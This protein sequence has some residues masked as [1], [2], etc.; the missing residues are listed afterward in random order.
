M[1]YIQLKSQIIKLETR[2]VKL[3]D[4]CTI[5]SAMEIPN[6]NIGKVQKGNSFF[7][8]SAIELIKILQD[9]YP[10]EQFNFI[11]SSD[12]CVEYINTKKQNRFFNIVKIFIIGSIIFAGASTALMAFQIESNIDELVIKYAQVFG[13]KEDTSKLAFSIPY[14]LGIAV[15][16][17]V[18]FNH[19]G[20]KKL[21]EDP[22]PIEIEMDEFDEKIKTNIVQKIIASKEESEKH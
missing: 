8:L 21:N 2:Q 20:N 17:I 13:V 6:F 4:I 9:K 19:F 7:A 18:F 12:I 15:G 14:P 10:T 22:T 11:G 1:I 16:I 5:N 3:Y